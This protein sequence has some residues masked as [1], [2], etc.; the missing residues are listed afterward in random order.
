MVVDHNDFFNALLT[1]I[2]AALQRL[3]D[4]VSRVEGRDEDGGFHFTRIFLHKG[5]RWNPAPNAA[6]RY[7]FGHH[8]ASCDDSTLSNGYARQNR[9]A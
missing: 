6:G 4:E 3:L 2:E 1:L 5:F 8:R 7:V 9:H